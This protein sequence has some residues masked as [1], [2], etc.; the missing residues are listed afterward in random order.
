MTLVYQL[1]NGREMRAGRQYGWCEHCNGI[2]DIEPDFST[3]F[4]KDQRIA[5]LVKQVTS[6]RFSIKKMF[7]SLSNSGLSSAESELLEIEFGQKIARSRNSSP[8]CLTCGIGDAGIVVPIGDYVHACG[9]KLVQAGPDDEFRAQWIEDVIYLDYEGC[10][11]EKFDGAYGYRNLANHISIDGVVGNGRYEGV[12]LTTAFDVEDLSPMLE[13][14]L[15]FREFALA[16]ES[17]I[18]AGKFD[19]PLAGFTEGPTRSQLQSL[20]ESVRILICRDKKPVSKWL[21]SQ[22]SG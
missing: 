9:G 2:R 16:V 3:Y 11:V 5:E 22:I 15:L 4:D 20:S 8:R 14:K 1:P 18:E 17:R 12:L 19:D 7:R 13:D 10:R 21:K 6:I